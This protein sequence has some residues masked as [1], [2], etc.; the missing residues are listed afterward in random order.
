MVS[1]EEGDSVRILNFEAKE[2]FE[3]FNRVIASINKI[4]NED[5]AGFFDLSTWIWG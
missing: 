1:S 2:I 3:S 4:S 5:V